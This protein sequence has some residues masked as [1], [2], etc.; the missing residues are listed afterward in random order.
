MM[1]D[2]ND[3]RTEMALLYVNKKIHDRF[4][5]FIYGQARLRLSFCIVHIFELKLKSWLDKSWW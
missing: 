5:D 2:C 4:E 1:V 3:I